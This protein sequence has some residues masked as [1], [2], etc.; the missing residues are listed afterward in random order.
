MKVSHIKVGDKL[1]DCNCGKGK[2]RTIRLTRDRQA[3]V[4]SCECG[5][6]L[7]MSVTGRLE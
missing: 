2:V 4:I 3:Y 7:Y 6:L 1:P 5:N